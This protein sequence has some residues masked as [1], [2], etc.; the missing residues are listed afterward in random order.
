MNWEKGTMNFNED[1]EFKKVQTACLY[2]FLNMSALI[3]KR[4]VKTGKCFQCCSLRCVSNMCTSSIYMY[5]FHS[6]I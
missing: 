4:K 1:T 3:V 5:N 6:D 2:F